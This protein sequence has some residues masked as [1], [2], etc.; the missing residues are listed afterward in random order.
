MNLVIVI[1]ELCQRLKINQQ[2]YDSNLLKGMLN[3]GIRANEMPTIKQSYECLIQNNPDSLGTTYTENQLQ[4]ERYDL[5]II[6]PAYNV[7]D[8][9]EECLNSI[10][11]QETNFTYLIEVVNDGSQDSTE[12]ILEKYRKYPNL[13]IIKQSNKGLSGARNTSLR[14]LSSKYVLFLDSDDYLEKGAIQNL[15]SKAVL[16]DSDIVEGG[17]KQ[18][19]NNGEI[20]HQVVHKDSFGEDAKKQLYGYPWGKLFK[21]ELFQN[22]CFPEGY[23]FEDTIMHYILH[24]KSKKIATISNNVY[25][26]RYNLSGITATSKKNNKAIDSFL[27]T[28]QILSDMPLHG[29]EI[30]QLIFSITLQQFV[31]NFRRTKRLS[32]D[33]QKSLFIQTCE[34]VDVY[35]SHPFKI[36]DQ[37]LTDLFIALKERDF[38]KY[39]LICSLYKN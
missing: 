13:N 14:D 7:E 21:S 24:Q 19:K 25:N 18:F 26:Y 9:I 22:L 37:M 11:D 4:E 31:M 20:V 1:G 36:E 35:F 5:K 10:I 8:Y 16:T 15:L 28:K 6:V 33:I 3:L 30:S 17:Y 12:Q 27:I 38:K 32:I 29:I 39:Y 2:V 23:W 34:L